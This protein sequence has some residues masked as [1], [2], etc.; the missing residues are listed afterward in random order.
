MVT[1]RPLGPLLATVPLVTPSSNLGPPRVPGTTHRKRTMPVLAM[2]YASPRMPLPM[3]ALLR[4][5]TDIPNDVL[6]SNCAHG[7]QGGGGRSHG[8]DAAKVGG[9]IWGGVGGVAP[10]RHSRR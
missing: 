9:G 7:A 10:C 6:P 2:A 8:W 4:L 5:K 3:M 1:S